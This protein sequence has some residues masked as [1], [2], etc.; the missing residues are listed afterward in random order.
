MSSAARAGGPGVSTAMPV[1]FTTLEPK[2]CERCG[3]SFFREANTA[4]IYCGACERVFVDLDA[5]QNSWME[6]TRAIEAQ[7]GEMMNGTE[8]Q[9]PQTSP[10]VTPSP[11]PSPAQKRMCKVGDCP[12]VLSYNNLTGYCRTHRG[13]RRHRAHSKANGHAGSA[14]GNG[15]GNSEAAAK[16]NGQSNG[17]E[18]ALEA[19]V[20]LV[21]KAMPLDEKVR[22][23]SSWL[24]LGEF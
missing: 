12:A 7:K 21:L 8:K 4:T 3:R 22:M 2:L 19:R 1:S 18:L 10:T 16:P 6:R 14:A 17:R 5:Q 15:H 23:I 13:R 11:A 24:R 9:K 20:S